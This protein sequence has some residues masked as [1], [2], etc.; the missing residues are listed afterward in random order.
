MSYIPT[1]EQA[2]ELVKRFN[3]EAFHIQHAQ[4]V[5]KVMGESIAVFHTVR[6]RTANR[7]TELLI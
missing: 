7:K 4:I 2:E 1:P 3:K 6:E 5:S